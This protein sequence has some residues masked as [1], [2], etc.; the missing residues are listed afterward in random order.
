MADGVSPLHDRDKME[1]LCFVSAIF[2]DV[3]NNKEAFPPENKVTNTLA[4]LHQV[5]SATVYRLQVFFREKEIKGKGKRNFTFYT[6]WRRNIILLS[7]SLNR[8]NLGIIY[9]L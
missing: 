3:F 6:C 9:Y 7:N 2:S 4:M 1:E 8:R 5:C